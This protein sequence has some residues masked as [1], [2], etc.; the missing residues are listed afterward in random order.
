MGRGWCRNAGTLPF[1]GADDETDVLPHARDDWTTPTPGDLPEVTKRLESP[2]S[3]VAIGETIAHGGMAVVHHGTQHVLGRAVAVKT[4]RRGSDDDFGRLLREARLTSRLEHPNI[5][6]VHDIVLDEEGTPQVVLKLVEGETW[7]ELL[8]DAERVEREH[9]AEDL[10]EWNLEVLRTVCLA[11]SFAHSRGVVHR[12][13]KPSNVMV[14]AFGEVYLLDWGIAQELEEASTDVGA[15]PPDEIAGTVAYMAPEQLQGDDSLI[16]PWTDVYLLGAT[17]YHALVGHAP[18]PGVAREVRVM[19]AIDGE[20]RT[21]TPPPALPLELRR[22]LARALA[23]EPGRRFPNVASFRRALIEFSD[24][25]AVAR[26]VERGDEERGRA[27]AA[28][29]PREIE[30]HLLAAD[31][32]Y[33]AALE[34]WPGARDAVEGARALLT[35]RIDHALESGE[36][37]LAQ[38]LSEGADVDD[39][40]RARVEEAVLEREREAARVNAMTADADVGLGLGARG[41]YGMLLGAVLGCFYVWTA[42]APPAEVTPFLVV[43]LGCLALV[44]LVVATS[45]RV[46]LANRLN[47]AV[48]QVTACTL[49]VMTALPVGGDAM[50]WSIAEI[51]TALLLLWSLMA[52]AI[53]AIVHPGG[54]FT[55][56]AFLVA[57]LV[58]A[59]T[60]SWLGP[61]TLVGA[62]V[63]VA[64]QLGLNLYFRRV[65]KEARRT[66]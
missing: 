54:L 47:R 36:V 51:Q 23:I 16:G 24:H 63:T 29:D 42:F 26:L 40:I 1:V 11:V 45:A 64:N 19:N 12:D 59:T 3:R 46:L 35:L 10:L 57:F 62:L 25:R 9:G 28:Q 44:V 53:A 52:V 30:R 8:D 56:G 31:V 13:I 60:P 17:L 27:E 43:P 38:R 34:E 32:A 37:R 5:M 7:A 22:I 66:E 55:A 6:P 4:L 65:R 49:V 21:P 33:S 15:L 48:I 50:S 39:E 41:A 14:G 18:F 58:A 2:T 61:A 20:I